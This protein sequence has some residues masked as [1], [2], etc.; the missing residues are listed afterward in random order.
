MC[1]DKALIILNGDYNSSKKEF[2]DIL[3]GESISKIIAVDGGTDILKN[4]SVKPDIIIGDL[5]SISLETKEY[6]SSIG[7]EIKKYPVEKD[8]TDSEIAVDYCSEMGI[9]SIIIT[10]AL[11]GRID[12]EIANIN[13]LEYIKNKNIDAKIIDNNIEISIID[14]KKIFKYKKGYRLS[15][16]A[17][18]EVAAGLSIS[19]CKYNLNSKDL[20]RYK[21]RGISNLILEDRAEV[22]IEDGLLICILENID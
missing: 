4:F 3:A 1:R 8:Q 10:A 12:Q 6:Y 16:L 13:L 22:E 7:V 19:G 14:D 2:E 17:Q 11:G 15:L 21:T 20:L 5:D 9:K 18:T